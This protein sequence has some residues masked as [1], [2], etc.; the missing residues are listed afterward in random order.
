MCRSDTKESAPY[1][2]SARSSAAMGLGIADTP[3]TAAAN[4]ITCSNVW[5]RDAWQ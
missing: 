3:S 2:K 1:L 4:E 5:H